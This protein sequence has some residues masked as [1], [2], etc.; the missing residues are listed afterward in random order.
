MESLVSEKDGEGHEETNSSFLHVVINMSGML[1]DSDSNCN[2]GGTSKL[3]AQ[4]LSS[5]SFQ[6][7]GGILMSLLIFVKVA[8]TAIFGGVK[9]NH[10]I[11][12]LQLSNIPAISGLYIF[13]YAGHIL[14]H[15]IYTAMKDP[16]KFTK[17]S[18][19]NLFYFSSF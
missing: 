6:S 2:I 8:C 9:A 17:A 14:F 1:I 7:T 16:S 10:S 19:L 11:P 12:T 15:N 13:S 18:Y 4:G 3:V 5:I